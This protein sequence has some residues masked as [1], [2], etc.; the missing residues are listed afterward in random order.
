M[1]VPVSTEQVLSY[2]AQE[3]VRATVRRRRPS[4]RLRG[5]LSG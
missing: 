3:R 4:P 2:V 5:D 1:T